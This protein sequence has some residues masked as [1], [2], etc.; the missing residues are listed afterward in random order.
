MNRLTKREGKHTVRIGN[1]WRRHD[2]VWDRLA[3][4]EDLGL[5]PEEIALLAKFYKERT[6]PEAIAAEM[7]LA[8][9]LL[10]WSNYKSMEIASNKQLNSSAHYRCSNIDCAK[11]ITSTVP[12]PTERLYCPY[13][14]SELKEV[15]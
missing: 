13:C 10:E 1:E 9:K 14:K 11:F 12:L 7:R 15:K 4:Y 5:T 8:E 3:E 2:P 6:S